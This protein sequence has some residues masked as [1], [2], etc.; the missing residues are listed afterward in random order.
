[1]AKQRTSIT[2]NPDLHDLGKHLAKEQHFDDFS[3]FIEHLI[4]SEW[5]RRHTS[6]LLEKLSPSAQNDEAPP[7]SIVY[8]VRKS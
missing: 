5:E 7:A 4:R 6:K 1:M 2:I 8:R 3:N